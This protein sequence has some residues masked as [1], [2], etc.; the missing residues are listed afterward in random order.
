[1]FI[2]WAEKGKSVVMAGDATFPVAEDA[3]MSPRNRVAL[4]NFFARLLQKKRLNN[5]AGLFCN[6]VNHRCLAVVNQDA[7]A[8]QF[9][10]GEVDVKLSDF[11]VQSAAIDA[12]NTGSLSFIAVCE[13]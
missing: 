6:W 1:M 12:K 11:S 7:L 9:E 4:R 3:T 5:A 8:A 10:L 2:W 13:T